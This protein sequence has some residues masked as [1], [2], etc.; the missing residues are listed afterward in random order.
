[1]FDGLDLLGEASERPAVMPDVAPLRLEP[2]NSG[3]AVG[4]QPPAVKVDT[5]GIFTPSFISLIFQPWT[6]LLFTGALQCSHAVPRFRFLALETDY[7]L[8]NSFI[9]KLF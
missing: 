3:S 1:M 8:V 4:I 6:C 5:S 7:F 9:F 2:A